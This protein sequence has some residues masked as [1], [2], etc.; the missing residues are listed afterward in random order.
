VVVL[1]AP[2][3]PALINNAAWLCPRL[4]L[5]DVDRHLLATS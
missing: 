4:S 5:G 3:L 2:P 1:I